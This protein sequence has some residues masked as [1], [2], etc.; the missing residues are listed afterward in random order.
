MEESYLDLIAKL[1]ASVESDYIPH[2]E[3][4]EILDMISRLEFKLWKYSH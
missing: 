3:K 4:K 1:R 2:R